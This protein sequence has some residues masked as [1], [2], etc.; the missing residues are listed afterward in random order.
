MISDDFQGA[1]SEIA[2]VFAKWG[3]LPFKATTKA[4]ASR[5]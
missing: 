5:L 2:H 1:A 3:H 4:S